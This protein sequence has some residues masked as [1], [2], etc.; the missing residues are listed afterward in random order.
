MSISATTH[1]VTITGVVA[2]GVTSGLPDN[3][4]LLSLALARAR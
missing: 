1:T 3:A 2:S 4:T